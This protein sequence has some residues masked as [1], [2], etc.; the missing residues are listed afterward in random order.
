MEHYI[1]TLV[2]TLMHALLITTFVL[3]M[4]LLVEY[5]TVQTKNRFIGGLSKNI[6]VQVLL[7]GLLGIIPGCLGTFFA[8]TLYVHKVI[9]FAALTT[10]MI[11]T[12]GDEAYVMFAT[13]PDKALWINAL[14]FAIAVATGFIL[15]IFLK[16]RNFSGIK[17]NHLR[18]HG[19]GESCYCFNKEEF[20][21]HMRNITFHRALLIVVITLLLIFMLAGQFG[22]KE[23]NYVK[24][25]LLVIMLFGL[26]VVVTVPDHFLD[27]HVWNHTIKKHLPRIFLWTFGALLIIEILLPWLNITQET[28]EQIAAKYYWLILL[29]AVLIG[30][31]PESGPHMVFVLL[32]AKGL[33]PLSVLLANSIVQDGH[34]SLPLLAESKKSFLYTKLINMAVAVLVAAI[35]HYGFNV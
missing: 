2:H 1:N 29:V 30:I 19:E 22:P 26:F 28:M 14:L 33:L 17:V 10:V 9:N 18:Y 25:T 5:L 24:I 34:G 8:V 31:I 3:G 11:A 32:F 21:D 13:M 15:N 20:K 23:W 27:E 7:A 12:S 35:M 4:M 16:D 6:W